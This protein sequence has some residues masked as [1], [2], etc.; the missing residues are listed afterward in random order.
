MTRELV[1]RYQTS[2]GMVLFFT[3]F[4][5]QQKLQYDR[6]APSQYPPPPGYLRTAKGLMRRQRSLGPLTLEFWRKIQSQRLK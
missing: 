3:G 6:E 5:K 2:V 1:I 4:A